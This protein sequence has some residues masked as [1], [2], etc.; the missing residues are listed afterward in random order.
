MT[1]HGGAGVND[2]GSAAR[3]YPTV[4]IED[5]KTL[6]VQNI[7]DDDCLLFMWVTSPMLDKALEL[8]AAWGFQYTTVAF[9]WDKKRVNPGYYTMSQT[10]MVLLFKKGKIPQPRGARNIRQLIREKRTEHS[11]KPYETHLRINMMFPDQDKIELFARRKVPGWHLWG[12]E[13]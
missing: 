8:G 4:K 6:P 5:L 1:Q 7:A 10:E 3:Y 12:N 9:V 2:T 13:V 11:R